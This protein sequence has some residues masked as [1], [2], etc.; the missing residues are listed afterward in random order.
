[1]LSSKTVFIIGAGAS[2]HLQFPSGLDLT[3]AISHIFRGLQSTSDGAAE[4]VRLFR[5]ALGAYEA[6]NISGNGFLRYIEDASNRFADSLFYESSID[7]FIN[8][9]RE[10]KNAVVACKIAISLLISQAEVN[11]QLFR[12]TTP[13]HVP[14]INDDDWLTKLYRKLG[15][16]V[17]ASNRDSLF[18]NVSFITFNYD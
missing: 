18:D 4:D 9:N 1:M 5:T 2:V 11:S 10:D 14:T 17:V 15:E 7:N 12:R 8:R 16:K 3:R 6:A 13:N